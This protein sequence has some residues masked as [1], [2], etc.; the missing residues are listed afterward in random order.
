MITRDNFQNFIKSI[1]TDTIVNCINSNGDFIFMQS[2]IFN[3]GAYATVESTDYSK[4]IQQDAENNG[5]LFCDK[6]TFLMLLDEI[7]ISL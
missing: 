4:E 3:T 5:W 2:H 1:P 6:D 7:N